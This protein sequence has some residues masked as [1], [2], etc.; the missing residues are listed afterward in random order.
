[1]SLYSLTCCT[2]S[3]HCRHCHLCAHQLQGLCA[4]R[5]R[6][7]FSPKRQSP[8]RMPLSHFR[9]ALEFTVSQQWLTEKQGRTRRKWCCV[10]LLMTSFVVS[11]WSIWRSNAVVSWQTLALTAALRSFCRM[12]MLHGIERMFCLDCEG[13]CICICGHNILSLFPVLLNGHA[14]RVLQCSVLTGQ[15]KCCMSQ[16]AYCPCLLCSFA[17]SIVLLTYLQSIN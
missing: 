1:M 4:A 17:Y 13:S 14:L 2:H 10:F 12:C 11:G 7:L 16:H 3:L 9:F 15:G 8:C 6:I 5:G